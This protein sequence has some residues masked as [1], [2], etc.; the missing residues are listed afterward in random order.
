MANKSALL[1]A[2]IFGLRLMAC[3]SADTPSKPSDGSTSG[4]M[5]AGASTSAGAGGGAS[6][7]ASSGAGGATGAGGAGGAT[8]A[9]TVKMAIDPTTMKPGATVT[10]TVTVTNFILEAPA[11]QPNQPGHGHYHIYLD[12]ASGINY[13][14]AEQSPSVP[15]KIPNNTAVGPHKLRC[16]VSDNSHAPLVPAVE[17]T[18][19][20]T[21]D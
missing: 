6:S 12:D 3:S 11:G 4:T 2:A 14:V 16:S 21:V 15:V 8:G 13:L 17:D 1:F 7:S 5:S 18:V 9:I 10:A 20:I 19:D